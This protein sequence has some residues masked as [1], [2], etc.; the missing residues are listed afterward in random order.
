VHVLAGASQ[1]RKQQRRRG[2][3]DVDCPGQ[4]GR[5]GA[6]LGD[7][8]DDLSLVVSDLDRQQL[9]ALSINDARPVVGLADIDADPGSV[10]LFHHARV[11]VRRLPVLTA[12]R[13]T[14]R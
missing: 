2:A 8:R 5:E 1:Q 12:A 3:D 4:L 6:R 13:G 10:P 14:P 11:S 7:E 9:L